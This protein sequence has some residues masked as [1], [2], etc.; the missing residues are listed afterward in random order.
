MDPELTL[1]KTMKV[2][3]QKEAVQQHNTQLK[4]SLDTKSPIDLSPIDKKHSS[5]LA[6]FI[7]KVMEEEHGYQAKAPLNPA[8]GTA[9]V[10]I[11][12]AH[13]VLPVELHA[14]DV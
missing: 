10:H 4:N 13:N 9:E 1:A 7:T 5:T 2:V 3:R 6:Q 14:S 11:L 8:H 12:L